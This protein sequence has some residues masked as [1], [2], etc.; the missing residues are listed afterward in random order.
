MGEIMGT[1]YLDRKNLSL[2]LDNGQM[3]IDE[4][5]ARRRGIPLRLLERVVIRGHVGFDSTLL[6]A[7]A[8]QGSAALF[9]SG[10]QGRRVAILLGAGHADARRRLAQYRVHDDIAI[11]LEWSRIVVKGKLRAQADTL[12][13]ARTLRPDCRKPLTDGITSL[14]SILSKLPQADTLD[15]I[16]GLEGAGAAAYFGA[17]TSIFPPALEF[18]NRNRRPPRDPVNACLSL[19]YTLLHF[20]AVN[21]CHGAGLDPLLGFFHEP[22]YGRE[23][24]AADLIEPLRARAD[25]W[26]WELFRGR[27][28][29]L[30]DF[31]IDQGSCL[32]GK[33]GR[34]DFYAAYETFAPAPRRWLRRQA[35]NLA[36]E[37]LARA[38]DLVVSGEEG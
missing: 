14:E 28:L 17:F 8:E 31:T 4:P 6:G 2:R 30:E 35:Y 38:P 5:G 34:Q 18:H 33:I 21:A 23:S 9:L 29:R 32:L 26:V 11:R 25:A 20:E 27:T 13:M 12:E 7:L 16:R 37:L 36:K 15:V 22:A 10:R 1:L 3:V 19:V 24:L